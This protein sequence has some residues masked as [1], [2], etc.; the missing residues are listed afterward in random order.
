[1][2]KRHGGKVIPV[3]MDANFFYERA[4]HYLDRNNYNKALKYFQRAVDQEPDNPVNH[5]NLAGVLAEMGLFEESNHILQHVLEKVDPNFAEGYFYMANNWAYLEEYEL[6]EECVLRYLEVDE[7]GEFREEAEEMLQMLSEMLGRPPR[8]LRPRKETMLHNLHDKA[9]RLLE[10]GRFAEATQL[11]ER[12]VA[13]EPS[14]TAA[15]N[16][17]TLAYFYQGNLQEA[18]RLVHGVLSEDPGNIHALCNLAVL[19]GHLDERNGLASVLARLKK[20]VP[21]QVD[22]LFKQATTLGILGE[23]EEAYVLFRKLIAMHAVDDVVLYHYTAV[24]AANTGRYEE[25]ARWWRRVVDRDPESPVPRFYLRVLEEMAVDELPPFPYQY[26]LPLEQFRLL[27][28][29]TDPQDVQ[30][31]W[32]RAMLHWG[33]RFGH[34]EMKWQVLHL[35]GSIGDHESI[36]MLRQFVADETDPLLK[37]MA[38][39]LLAFLGEE[40]ETMDVAPY[41]AVLAQV[42]Q[43]LSLYAP[44]YGVEARH[45]WLHF[46]LRVYPHLP[47]IQKTESW[48]AA[49]EYLTLKTIGQPVTQRQIADSYPVSVSTLSK[50]VQTIRHYLE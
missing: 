41:Q 37:D 45:L 26:H 44:Q 3:E 10:E 42:Q 24:A 36:L 15:R 47:R 43:H 14:F 34:R 40:V 9:R 30:Y 46:L 23:H 17:L 5:C 28:M 13:E 27:S 4:L 6:A 35:L 2:E 39:F 32:L 1:M 48:A 19:Y 18:F 22:Q 21:L 11:L 12:I 38:T 16:N 20:I 8:T 29:V 7:N 33:L 49:L 31:R 50:Y 25:A